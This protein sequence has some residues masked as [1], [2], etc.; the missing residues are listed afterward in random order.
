VEKKRKMTSLKGD[1]AAQRRRNAMAKHLREMRQYLGKKIEP[2][3]N[4]KRAKIDKRQIEENEDGE[5]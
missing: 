5:H 2:K 1:R 4:Y 3:T